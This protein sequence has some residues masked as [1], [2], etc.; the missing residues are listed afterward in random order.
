VPTQPF[1][2]P[3]QQ[4]PAFPFH[5]TDILH[6]SH[7]NELV[8]TPWIVA[9]D[10]GRHALVVAVR[11]PLEFDDAITDALAVPLCVGA[12]LA[13]TLAHLESLGH[14]VPASAAWVHAGMWLAACA[15]AAQLQQHGLLEA[16]Q[17]A[18]A[19]DARDP[20]APPAL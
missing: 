13:P 2:H 10:R 6:T 4:R 20:G 16:V 5:R 8:Q 7:A 17:G 14:S 18:A 1:A 9:V 15:I 19:S 11:G 12:E 3:A